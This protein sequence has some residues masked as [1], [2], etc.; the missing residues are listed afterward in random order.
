[1]AA[2]DGSF[3]NVLPVL[4]TDLGDSPA[5]SPGA[6]LVAVLTAASI[7][8]LSWWTTVLMMTLLAIAGFM[9]LRR[10]RS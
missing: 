9:V 3:L 7:P 6:T 2:A 5:A 1:M 4:Q 8:T 10:S